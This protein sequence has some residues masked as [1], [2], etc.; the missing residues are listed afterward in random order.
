M[1]YVDLQAPPRSHG[2][3]YRAS[4]TGDGSEN[5]LDTFPIPL[6]Q[7]LD[8]SQPPVF[9]RTFVLPV[10]RDSEKQMIRTAEGMSW[11]GR[12]LDESDAKAESGPTDWHVAIV[13]TAEAWFRDDDPKDVLYCTHPSTQ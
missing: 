12:R 7:A 2:N 8:F 13:A 10:T 6:H 1:A 3:W 5:P 4:P 11:G 9:Q